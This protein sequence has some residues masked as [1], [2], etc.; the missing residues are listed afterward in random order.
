MKRSF[1]IFA[2]WLA[3]GVLLPA[4]R[5]ADAALIAW[6]AD[7]E[8]R[9]KTVA[10]TASDNE[11]HLNDLQKE[12]STLGEAVQ[13]LRQELAEFR[14][15]AASTESLKLLADQLQKVEN[16]RLK[17][18]ELVQNKLADL[19]RTI[20]NAPQLPP[21]PVPSRV[22]DSGATR[23]NSTKPNHSKPPAEVSDEGV[24]HSVEGGNT[25]SGIVSAYREQG[26]R[27]T[28]RMIKEANPTVKNWEMLKVGQ[29]IWIPKPK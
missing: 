16:N 14:T 17:D 6:Q 2:C 21:P 22:S 9:L 20:A 19:A 11:R 15:A 18:V 8:E 25:L 26:I 7:F 23:P 1:Y 29:K 12:V 13:K 3:L 28:Q 4:S 10:T 24:W 27:V 5:A